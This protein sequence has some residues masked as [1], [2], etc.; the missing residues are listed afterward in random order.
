MATKKTVA[1]KRSLKRAPDGSVDA[2]EFLERLNGP[3][4]LADLL[5]AIREGEELSL[6]A[7]GALLGISAAKLCDIEQGRRGVSPE[8]AAAWARVLGYSEEQ[9]IRLALQ[10]QLDEAQLAFDVEVAP[11]PRRSR[12]G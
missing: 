5:R 6:A 12:T 11:R 8:R 4:K 10:A 1:K 7:F 2:R 9:F 3:L